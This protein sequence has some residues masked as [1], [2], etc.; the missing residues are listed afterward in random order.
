MPI[1][2]E[3]QRVHRAAQVMP[4]APVST[5]AIFLPL[6]LASVTD[7]SSIISDEK[8]KKKVCVSAKKRLFP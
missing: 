3:E 2:Q 5:G 8:K 1:N 4:G 7:S 6:A